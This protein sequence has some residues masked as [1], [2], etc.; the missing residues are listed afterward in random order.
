MPSLSMPSMSMP[1]LGAMK[2]KKRQEDPLGFFRLEG[3]KVK[4]DGKTLTLSNVNYDRFFE[5]NQTE[6]EKG[7]KFVLICPSE[8]QAESWIE[9]LI[10]GGAVEN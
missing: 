1:S 6:T 3:I 10:Y 5:N 7:A 9:S 8:E 4:Q 2:R